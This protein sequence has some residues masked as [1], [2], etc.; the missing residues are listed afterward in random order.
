MIRYLFLFISGFLMT[1]FILQTGGL[2]T[3]GQAFSFVLPG[4]PD[5]ASKLRL[6]IVS[7]DYTPGGEMVFIPAG[8]FQMGCSAAHNGGLPCAADESPLH[9]VYLDAYYIDAAEVTN[10]QY[11]KCVAAGVCATP[12][13]HSSFTRTSY[14]DN[15]YYA[16]YPVIWVS[17]FDAL[18]Y[19][20]WVG[21]RLPTEAE[22][23]K[24][25]RGAKDTRAFPWGDEA[26]TCTLANSFNNAKS[27]YCVGDT[28]A[29]GAYPAGVSP[30]GVFSLSGNVQEW[31]Y[32]YWQ[33]DYYTIS[34]ANNPTGPDIGYERVARGGTWGDLP[35]GLRVAD[36]VELIPSAASYTCGFRCAD[37]P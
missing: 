16:N 5:V 33:P 8:D 20:N 28:R 34:P 6:P 36:R 11:A 37:T 31:V 4:E 18:N 1:G 2:S 26:P 3:T 35:G 23:E 24:A 32:D 17:W 27:T 13:N 7:R 21:K 14:Y 30:Y 22:W 12:H 9:K 29:V 25:A 15:L 10:G 19:C